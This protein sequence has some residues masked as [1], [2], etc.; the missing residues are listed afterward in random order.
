MNRARLGFLLLTGLPIGAGAVYWTG[1]KKLETAELTVTAC[2][3]GDGNPCTGSP[4]SEGEGIPDSVSLP[5]GTSCRLGSGENG[6]CTGEP[7]KN[8]NK[9]V[10][11]L[12]DSDCADGYCHENQCYSCKDEIL[13]GDEI[14]ADCG[15][16]H[17]GACIGQVCNADAGT[18]CAPNL[19]C[20]DGVCCD[21]AMC[22]TCEACNINGNGTCK[23]VPLGNS[24]DTCGASCNGS[25]TC[26]A[27]INDTCSTHE[28]CAWQ[29]C[30]GRC[31]H[32]SA[33][34]AQDGDCGSG[35]QCDNRVCL[36]ACETPK[37][38][39]TGYSC[40]PRESGSALKGCV[41][42]N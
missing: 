5:K 25:G 6:R 26:K 14:Q 35:N 32:G 31:K 24:D 20:T 38:C 29:F 18:T 39:P 23:F 12:D 21:V 34:C 1:C 8:K 41:P 13:N 40:K 4:C 42:D 30:Q 27:A 11:C 22:G 16:S 10:P 19:Y 7:D 36:Q 3:D 9:C 15:G 37:D 2:D 33:K 28:D 17:C